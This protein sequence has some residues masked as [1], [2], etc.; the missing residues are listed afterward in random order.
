[1]GRV[2]EIATESHLTESTPQNGIQ[3]LLSKNWGRIE[4]VMPKK[5]SAERLYQLSVSAINTTPNLARC[6]PASLLSCVMKCSA[7]GVEPSAVDGLGMSYILPYR[8]KIKGTNEFQYEATFILGYKGMIALARRSG[9][10]KSISARAVY[11]GDLFDFK[12]GLEDLLEHIPGNEKENLTHVYMV[13]H[14]MDGGHHIEVMTK[15]D[16]EAIRKRSKAR[17][18]GPWVTDYEAMAKKTVIR[19]A[20]PYLPVSIEAANAAAADET[21]GGFVPQICFAPVV[22]NPIL[23]IAPV[24]ENSVIEVSPS[25]QEQKNDQNMLENETETVKARAKNDSKTTGLPRKAFCKS[26]GNIQENVSI[27]ASLDDLNQ[28]LCCDKPGYEWAE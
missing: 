18:G 27:D 8:N 22:E 7:L 23:D 10:I 21:D 17:D 5:M 28:F 11:E 25:K 16:I 2:A 20:F 26:C 6:T 14:F 13:A 9:E 12:Y 15:E 24:V 4:A 1:M 3:T 19:R